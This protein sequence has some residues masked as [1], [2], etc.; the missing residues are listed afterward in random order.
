MTELERSSTGNCAKYYVDKW[1]KHKSESVQEKEMH[2]ILCNFANFQ[3]T[4]RPELVLINKKRLESEN[5]R[6]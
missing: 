4:A 2:K 6:K 5:Q 1:C 3:I